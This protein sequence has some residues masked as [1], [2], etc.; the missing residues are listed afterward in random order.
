MSLMTTVASLFGRNDR[1]LMVFKRNNIALN[2]WGFAYLP[3][4]AVAYFQKW[5]E[6]PFW[7]GVEERSEK[8][9]ESQ[10]SNAHHAAR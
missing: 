6:E 1:H 10:N 5:A 2:W 7:K 8:D 9:V 3:V 4:K